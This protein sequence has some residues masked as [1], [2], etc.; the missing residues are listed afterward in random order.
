MGNDVRNQQGR[1][2]LKKVFYLLLFTVI[3]GVVMFISRGTYISNTLKRI[4]LPE[5]EDMFGQRVIA[6]KIYINIFPL[7]I[8]AKE[9]K[10]FTEDGDR[11]VFANR[12]KGYIDL[13]GLL[14]KR[15]FIRRLVI[16]DPQIS[17]RRVQVDEVIKH[18]RAYLAKERKTAFKVEIKVIE[19][20]K[21][22]VYIR[23][24]NFKGIVGI[25][26]LASELILGEKPEI[27]TSV[28]EFT[29]EKEKWPEIKGNLKTSMIIKDNRIDIKRLEVGMYGSQFKGEGFYSEGTGTLKS[30][31]DL[32]VESIKHMFN[33]KQEGEGRISAKGEIR[34]KGN[35]HSS[36]ALQQLRNVFIDLKLNGDFYLQT[37][38]ELLHVQEKL[39]GHI[40][41]KGEIKGYLSDISGKAKA[42]LSKG[43]LF[44]VD[45]DSL[46]CEVLYNDGVMKFEDGS[47]VLYNGTAQANASLNI[48]HNRSYTLH[49]T[50]DSV[51]STAAL[52]LIGWNPRIPVGKVYGELSTSGQEFTPEGW[53]VYRALSNVERARIQHS[54]E[55]VLDRIKDIKGNYSFRDNII[56]FSNMQLSTSIS[57]LYLNGTVDIANKLLNLKSRLSTN[58]VSDLSGPYYQGAKGRGNFLGEI[59]G[60]FD[61]PKIS[62]RATFSDASIEGYR[63]ENITTD[64][65][66]EKKL[67]DIRES[68]FRSHSEKHILKGKILFPEAKELFDLSMPV[69]DLRSIL[70]NADVTQAV[71]L[72]SKDLSASGRMA[73]DI[74]IEGKGKEVD[75]SG[76]A[77]IENGSVR[78]IPFDS[79]S[80]T[81]SYAA[82]ELLLKSLKIVRGKSILTAEGKI[83]SDRRFSYS[84][85]SEKLFLKDMGFDYMPEDAVMTV[86]SKGQGTI[87]NPVITLNAQIHGGTFKGRNMG[88]GTVTVSVQNKKILLNASLF[89]EKMK[90]MGSGRLDDTLPWNAELSIQP[91]RYDFLIS[92]ILKDVPEDLQLTLEGRVKMEGD[93]KNIIAAADIDHLT[94][95]LFDQTFSNDSHIRFL[96]HNKKLSL[97]AFTVK[98][99]SA[100]FRLQGGVEIGKEYD[101]S[102]EGGS[103]LSPLKGLSKKIGY[104]K[105]DAE[106]AFSIKG[107]WD[108]PEINGG[109]SVSDASFGLRDYPMYISSINGDLYID[110]NRIVLHRLSGKIGG[111]SVTFSGNVYLTGF[112]M[113]RFY[114][115][116][117]LDNITTTVSKDFTANFSGDLLYKGTK[118]SQS[119]IGDIKINRGRYKKTIEWRSWLLEAKAKEIPRAEV[120]VFEQT[121]L[122]I[123]IS[124][125]DNIYIDTNVARA[126]VRIRGD[127]ILKGTIAN[128][129]LLGRFEST[130]G[131][132]YFRNNEFRIVYASTDFANP[133]RIM[134]ILNFTAE[135]SVQGYSIRLTLEGQIDHFTLALTSDPHLEEVDILALLTVGQ[136]GKQLKGLEGGIGAGEATSFLTG[137]MQ[138]VLEERLR[139]ITGLDRVQVDSYV[140]KTTATVKPRVTVAKRLVGDRFFVTYTTLLGSTE[141][142]IIKLEYLLSKNVSLI[143]LRDERGSMGGDVKFRFE[144]K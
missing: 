2:R 91:G 3:I 98:S 27:K 32:F 76:K 64:F 33:L 42:T 133:N 128:P 20:L 135:T 43:N 59:T 104:L 122:N 53:F 29:V 117:N 11:I 65:S 119:I 12:V 131:Y 25:K 95:S 26:G 101:I 47:A 121:E 14:S 140:S 79:A 4:I 61:D 102:L 130:E 17:A 40:N 132:V 123:R 78:E 97:T 118:D 139:T 93:R 1:G 39:R 110:G 8:E 105:G 80:G 66:Y 107:K 55:N 137:K 45:I 34:V 90:L 74:R 94:L 134:P 100:S 112:R 19:V 73:A 35:Q 23:D 60:S 9:L 88:S 38:M 68:L 129:I 83:S 103:S 7:F 67:L 54:S 5:L 10:I 15:L 77:S 72:F 21:G 127:M 6:N 84:A 49:V 22:D 52:Q 111:G 115:E 28:K 142:E 50:V 141:E 92:S 114:V 58:N 85:L 89:N 120:S 36:T 81:F 116:A 87:D 63:V 18:V 69:Y 136:V 16:K 143:G 113:K 62:G 44:S 57:N 99:G 30:E 41:F 109:M 82:K 48:L 86:H 138:D 124:A 70:K 106:F 71:R 75:V 24:E 56:S 96:V 46:R 31:I 108:S 126:P 51:D 144:F 13:S 37:L 125:S